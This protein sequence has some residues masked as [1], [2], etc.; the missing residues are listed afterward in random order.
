MPLAPG[1]YGLP[2]P[3]VVLPG[4]LEQSGSPFSMASA[5]VMVV[6]VSRSP[7]R[8]RQSFTWTRFFPGT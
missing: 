6:R 1:R 2:L 8:R 7:V 5:K 4:H 3:G